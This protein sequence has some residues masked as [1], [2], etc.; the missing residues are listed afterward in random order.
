MESLGFLVAERFIDID[1]V[2]KTP[3]FFV[4][5]SWD[6]LK[7]VIRDIR[8]MQPDPFLNEYYQWLAERLNERMQLNQRKPFYEEGN[9]RLSS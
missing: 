6:K 7:T 2:D 9:I 8:K 4:I 5:T 1:L 3:G